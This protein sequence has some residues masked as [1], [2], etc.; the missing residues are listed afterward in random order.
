MKA[1][2]KILYITVLTIP[3]L[4]ALLGTFLGL[5]LLAVYHITEPI[6]HY[7]IS[8]LEGGKRILYV[9]AHF[10]DKPDGDV[11]YVISENG[12]VFTNTL[13]QDEWKITTFTPELTQKT[14]PCQNEYLEHL[15][16]KTIADSIGVFR[17]GDYGSVWQCYILYSDGTMQVWIN[18]FS[19]FDLL[20][21]YLSGGLGFVIGVV[22]GIFAS[23]FIWRKHKTTTAQSITNASQQSVHLT[24][25]ILRTSQAVSHALAFFWLDG[26]A[27]PA[28]AQVSS[29]CGD[30]PQSVGL[31]TS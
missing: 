21:A 19:V 29:M 7:D 22:F 15:P 3:L 12:T 25:G 2:S 10:S 16:K 24:L 9:E 5:G 26:F 28:P 13:F 30:E 8:P 23:I 1:N 11:L 27:V 6:E 18:S 14:P 20:T 4:S 17:G 31:Y